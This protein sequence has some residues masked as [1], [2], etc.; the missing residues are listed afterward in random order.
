[1]VSRNDFHQEHMYIGGNM[2]LVQINKG[3]TCIKVVFQEG[4]K[5]SKLED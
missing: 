1:M 3:C 5:T 4:G 2:K